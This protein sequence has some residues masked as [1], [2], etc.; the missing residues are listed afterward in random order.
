MQ[1]RDP[2]RHWRK[3]HTP[4]R[5]TDTPLMADTMWRGG[6]PDTLGNDGA[7]PAYNGEWSGAGYEFKHFAIV[8]HN[9]GSQLVFFDGSARSKRVRELWALPW[10]KEFDV[11]YA[12]RQGASFFPAWMP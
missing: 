4:P 10:H 2:A 6:G 5:P 8:R 9:K 12:A 7:R 11:D 3:I 1:G